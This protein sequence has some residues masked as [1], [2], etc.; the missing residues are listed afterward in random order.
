MSLSTL[1]RLVKCKEISYYQPTERK[2]LFSDDHIA[3][4]LKR[5]EVVSDS[6]R[7]ERRRL[8]KGETD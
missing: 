7:R 3:A 1:K 8:G 6:E 2:Q 4:F 5:R